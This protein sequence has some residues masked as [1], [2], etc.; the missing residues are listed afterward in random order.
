MAT[1]LRHTNTTGAGLPASCTGSLRDATATPIKKT[2]ATASP[3]DLRSFMQ[4]SAAHRRS[5]GERP[6]PSR[7]Y[8]APR[9]SRANPRRF[10]DRPHR[11]SRPIDRQGETRNASTA[12]NVLRAATFARRS[13]DARAAKFGVGPRRKPVFESRRHPDRHDRSRAD[14]SRH[15]APPAYPLEYGP[16]WPQPRPDPADRRHQLALHRRARPGA[17]LAART[18]HRPAERARP[19]AARA[20]RDPRSRARPDVL[21]PARRDAH[22]AGAVAVSPRAP[23]RSCRRRDDDDPPAS[24]GN[25][26]TARG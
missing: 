4:T 9:S 11:R 5:R 17:G 8:R 21:R 13:P 1:P 26:N 20:A 6:R 18:W 3:R 22:T 2:P 23:Q 19:P 10:A 7:R 14:R 15:T 16:P 12:T 25:G 24:R